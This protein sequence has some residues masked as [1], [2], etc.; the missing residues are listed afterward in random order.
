MV[1]ND[2]LYF[3]GGRDKNHDLSTF[4]Q[5]YN[6]SKVSTVDTT[7]I[8]MAFPDAVLLC[9]FS[10]LDVVDLCALTCVSKR[11]QTVADDPSLW[12]NLCKN[13]DMMKMGNADASNIDYKSM[14]K[15]WTKDEHHRFKP[16]QIAN[17]KKKLSTRDKLIERMQKCQGTKVPFKVVLVGDDDCGKTS[18]VIKLATGVFPGEFIPMVFDNFTMPVMHRGV[19]WDVAVWDTLDQK[20]FD[21]LRPLCYPQT[22]CFI[23][24]FSVA[25]PHTFEHVATKWF[26]EISHHCP[27]TPFILMATKTDLY[28]DTATLERLQANGLAMITETQAHAM[29]TSI[30][31]MGVYFTSAL[32]E[33]GLE[34]AFLGTIDAAVDNPKDGKRKKCSIQ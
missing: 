29:A 5:V 33:E 23:I 12:Q 30:G 18:F 32:E 10:Y 8:D 3:I 31:A 28:Q 21:R 2:R 27:D 14:V 7:L 6:L 1:Y 25:S 11:F 20:K 34:R 19:R 26:K 4:L 13:H 16:I 17:Q 24:I 9:V 22:D 15:R